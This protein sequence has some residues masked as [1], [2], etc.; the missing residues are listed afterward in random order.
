[1]DEVSSELFEALDKRVNI[2]GSYLTGVAEALLPPENNYEIEADIIL[3]HNLSIQLNMEINERLR[4]EML[5]TEQRKFLLEVLDNID[6]RATILK[7]G[8]NKQLH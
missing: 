2:V 3:T 4:T 5:T 8:F 7:L 6:K 1:M